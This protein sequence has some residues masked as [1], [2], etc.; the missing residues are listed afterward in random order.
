MLKGKIAVV[1]GASGGMGEGICQVLAEAGAR[2]V[3][4]D[5]SA[6]QA[7]LAVKRLAEAG[8][9]DA[10]AISADVSK[11]D[12]VA[13]AFAEIDAKVGRVDVLVNNAGVRQ[14]GDT[15][16]IAPAEWD[17][18]ISVNLN[19]PFYCGREAALRMSKS[20]GGAIVNVASVAGLV[21]LRRRPA[22]VA[23]K[24]GLVG[25]T[26]SMAFELAPHKIRVNAV[27]P[28]VI[29]T[30]MTQSYFNDPDFVNGLADN[31]ALGG[32]T[33]LSVARAILFLCTPQSDYITGVTLPVDGGFMAE[34]TLV[35]SSVKSFTART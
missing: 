8:Y 9:K 13:K 30:P 14:I 18:V 5:V 15:L 4:M 12:S 21:A 24:H 33:P 35:S 19:G 11:A 27:A 31:V 16:E 6:D 34:K 26:K 22:Y 3:A 25:L 23:A 1:T 7:N 2:I 20:G 29:K 10:V 32:G 17:R 28:G